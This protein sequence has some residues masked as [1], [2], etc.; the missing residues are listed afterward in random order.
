MALQEYDFKMQHRKGSSMT[1]V[2]A[3]SRIAMTGAI[4]TDENDLDKM[5]QMM[6]RRDENIESIQKY[7]GTNTMPNYLFE[8]GMVF[9]VGP[10]GKKQLMVPKN[11]ENNM[12]LVHEKY[13]HFGVE[14][15]ANQ[16]Q[17]H[18]WFPNMREKLDRFIRNCLKCIY[19]S[20]S[21]RKNERQLYNIQKKPIPFD[22][23]HIDH[24]GPLPSL[25][26]RHKHVFGV[27]DGFTK[28]VKL[29]AVNSN[30]AKEACNALHRYFEHYSRPRRIISDRGNCFTSNEFKKLMSENNIEHIKVAVQ[31]PQ[32]NGQIER[33]HRDLKAM[34]AKLAESTT[35]ADWWLKLTQA[36]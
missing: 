1:H 27:I 32:S 24:F 23:V 19:Y 36:K 33:M 20:T 15:C 31:S 13:G 28:F 25:N 30:G 8:D 3:L 4:E 5:I 34:L 2:D 18:Y 11:L 21:P 10:Y 22:T 17:K 9:K 29:Y 6:Q 12:R 35:H 16:I 14:K 7:L 26:S